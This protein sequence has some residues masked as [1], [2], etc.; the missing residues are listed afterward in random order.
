MPFD[1]GGNFTRIHNWEDDRIND[2]EIV[3][4]HHDE[5]DDNFADGL[6][7]TFLRDGRV[8][9]KGDINIAGFKLKNLA[10]ATAQ[11]EATNLQQL[12]DAVSSLQSTIKNII[13]SSEKLGD[14][15][16]SVQTSNHGN[17]FLCNGQAVS[18]T[19]YSELFA[20]IGTKFGAGD[21]TTTFN[22]PDYRGKFLRGLGGNSASDIY[23]T[24]AEGLPDIKGTFLPMR[25]ENNSTVTG[26]FYDLTTT[27]MGKNSDSHNQSC[28]GT[29]FKASLS[30][31]IYGASTHVTPINQAV[32]YFIKIKLES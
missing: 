24:Q 7:Q 25:Y 31:P 26:A 18:R 9:M 11:T 1:S 23:S 21:G 6:S 30:N 3:T 20:L 29:G 22:L 8:A 19:T 4:D 16:A 10:K 13:N 27:T 15:K 28:N 17:W 14:I 5:E 12:N 2:I 32:N